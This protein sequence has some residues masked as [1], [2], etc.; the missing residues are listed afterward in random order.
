MS[1]DEAKDEAERRFLEGGLQKANGRVIDLA[2]SLG[3][4][5]SY[6]QRLLKKHG[7]TKRRTV[8]RPCSDGVGK[9]A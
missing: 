9:S 5:R 3:L 7:L 8:E 2:R 1:L 4:H 6:V